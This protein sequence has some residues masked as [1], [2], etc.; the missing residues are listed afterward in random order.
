MA[1]K[2]DRKTRESI[3]YITLHAREIFHRLRWADCVECPYCGEKHIWYYKN[4]YYK[5]SH[6]HKRFTDTSNTIFHSTKVSLTYWL[7]AIYLLSIGKGISSQELSRFLQVT[8]KT[9]WYMLHKIRYAFKQDGTILTG[10]I[11]V[12]EVYLGGKW[13][14]IIIPKKIDILK[15]YGLWYEGDER[16][17]WHKRNIHQAISQYKQPVYGMND[18]SRIVLQALPNRFNSK[19]LLDITR[20]H[21]DESLQHIISDQA[22]YYKDISASGI[23]VVQMNHSHREFRNGDFSSNRIEGTFSHVKRRYRC[24]YVRPNKK[25]IQLYLNEFAFRWNNRESSNMD[26]IASGL[27]SCFTCG[28]VTRKDID[29]YNWADSFPQ[30]KK[31]HKETLEDWFR[32]GWPD[33]ARM[34]RVQGVW[35]DKI[36]FESLKEIWEFK[37]ALLEDQDHIVYNYQY[38]MDKLCWFVLYH[39]VFNGSDVQINQRKL[40]ALV[41]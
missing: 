31:K 29:L 37:Q 8:Q 4:G 18:G 26:R 14:S 3:I 40:G 25:Y 21:S 10:D 11:A 6:C 12:D 9:A 35:Y 5:C 28:R 27:H 13:S 1:T 19:D 39:Y 7:V 24:H 20:R 23:N 38:I 41:S 32:I 30:R 17:T 15:R 36:E 33:C 34:I 22:S 16:R 2:I